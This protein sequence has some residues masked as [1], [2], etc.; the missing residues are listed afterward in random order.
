MS[1]YLETLALFFVG[2]T[3]AFLVFF[4]FAVREYR[5]A[6]TFCAAMSGIGCGFCYL[7]YYS[8]YLA[9]PMLV[10]FAAVHWM[11]TRQAQFSKTSSISLGGILLVLAPFAAFDLRVGD[12][13]LR[14]AN[15]LSLLSGSLSPYREA[16][17]K[18]ANPIPIVCDNLVLSLKSFFR[19]GVAGA[20][21]LSSA[22]SPC[23]T[24]F[25][26]SSCDGASRGLALVL[27]K[28]EL[29][30]VFLVIAA[31][32]GM[33][34]ITSPPP[35]CHRFS[36]AFPFLVILMTL[37][38]ELLLRLTNLRAGLRYVLA[39]V[40]LLT[41]AC[42]NESRLA[43]AIFRDQSPDEPRIAEFI[44]QRYGARR[45][46]VAA[47]S[48][49]A[50]QKIFYFYDRK[51]EPP[52]R[53]RSARQSAQGIQ[54]RREVR[55]RHDFRRCFSE[56]LRKG[57]PERAVLPD[58]RRLQHF[59]QLRG[60]GGMVRVGP[61]R[62][63]PQTGTDRG[64]ARNCRYLFLAT[65]LVLAGV[66]SLLV[67]RDRWL[68]D[69]PILTPFDSLWPKLPFLRTLVLP[70]YFALILFLYMGLI[71][72]FSF[73]KDDSRVKPPPPLLARPRRAR[74]PGP[75]SRIGSALLLLS[76][77][78]LVVILYRIAARGTL[79]GWDLVAVISLGLLG[80]I[81]REVPAEAMARLW[82]R[83][84]LVL[85][86][87]VLV[88]A[89]LI[90]TLASH[91]SNKHREWLFVLLLL[92]STLNLLRLRH[93]TRPTTW[94]ILGSMVLFS[95]FINGWWFTL[96]GDESSSGI[97]PKPRRVRHSARSDRICFRSRAGRKGTPTSLR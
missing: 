92:L 49:F 10:A 47:F 57:R 58:L 18:G 91:Y 17:A 85:I 24:R 76:S 2:A 56:E 30:F 46:Y 9:F 26:S 88:H 3:A 60:A 59:R 15:D 22:T 25:R 53:D 39:G 16:I 31:C 32:V 75:Q 48:A 23:L 38:F 19:N 43:E 35:T 86:A 80:R 96:V 20:G 70:S 71:V 1:V 8:S 27:R 34:A 44:N 36:I 81:L 13:V 5:T 83:K 66:P 33:V 93:R 29:L 82:H 77:L 50:F 67:V 51:G 65:A 69:P 87:V 54:P 41:F 45:L 55:L 89:S 12:Y 61:A 6:D 42:V 74:V 11:R 90:G 63:D 97:S 68:G 4:Y 73:R 21:G 94:I 40:L 95:L 79:P 37:P 84:F 72:L 78:A 64:R 7:M 28:S 62:I 14:R 52:R